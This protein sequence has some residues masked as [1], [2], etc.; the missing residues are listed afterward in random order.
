MK[1]QDTTAKIMEYALEYYDKDNIKTNDVVEFWQRKLDDN[2]NATYFD[3]K[4]NQ[5]EIDLTTSTKRQNYVQE[6][7]TK[8]N[9]HV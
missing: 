9:L 8:L 6:F 2:G 1:I 7:L 3:N 4:G 5:K